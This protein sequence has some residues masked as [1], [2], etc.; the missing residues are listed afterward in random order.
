MTRLKLGA[1]IPAQVCDSPVAEQYA[2]A[3]QL[4]LTGTPG[5]ITE[6]GKLAIGFESAELLLAA[7][8]MREGR[9]D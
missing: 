4:G 6:S 7:V 8:R 2:L 5:I 1:P 3:K 9:A